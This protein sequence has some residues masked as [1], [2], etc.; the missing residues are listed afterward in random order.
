[1]LEKLDARKFVP[2]HTHA[3]EDLAPLITVNRQA[4]WDI[5]D[6]IAFD[7]MCVSG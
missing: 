5:F 4:V 3:T 6:E 1:M 7:M 2:A